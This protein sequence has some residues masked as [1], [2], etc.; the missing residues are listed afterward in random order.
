MADLLE[1]FAA[2]QLIRAKHRQPSQIFER[3]RL[4]KNIIKVQ[5]SKNTYCKAKR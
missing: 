1:N 3:I 4:S 5:L 2:E